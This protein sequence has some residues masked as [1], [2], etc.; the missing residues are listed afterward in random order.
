MNL[1]SNAE[2]LEIGPDSGE[3]AFSAASLGANMWCVD[4]NELAI[5]KTKELFSR[6]SISSKLKSAKQGNFLDLDFGHQFHFVV[7]EGLIHSVENK[8]NFVDKMADLLMPQGFL[9]LSYY[10]KISIFADLFHSR[11]FRSVSRNFLGISDLYG[12]DIEEVIKFGEKIF[13]NKWKQK[14][15]I[16]SL[17]TWILD[18]LLNPVLESS[19]TLDPIETALKLSN[20]KIRYWSSYPSFINEQRM[21]WHRDVMNV[22]EIDSELSVVYKQRSLEF[23]LGLQLPSSLTFDFNFADELYWNCLC[24]NERVSEENWAEVLVILKTICVLVEKNPKISIEEKEKLAGIVGVLVNI[25]SLLLNSNWEA[26]I[27][28]LEEPS[29]TEGKVFHS[30]WGQPNHYISFKRE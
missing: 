2:Y 5:S 25:S 14:N 9:I 22:C 28:L 20:K 30:F 4:A 16:R 6:S 18:I 7:A 15:H 24:L 1:L 11:L 29:G 26:L 23:L 21:R 13:Q 27:K 8:V 3:N 19:R 12:P 17:R 10:D